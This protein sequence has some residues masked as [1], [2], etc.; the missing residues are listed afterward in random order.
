[1]QAINE[2]F[3]GCTMRAPLPV[4]GK[5]SLIRH[6]S[7]N[8]FAGV[9]SPFSVARYHSLTIGNIPH[10]LE[11]LAQTEDGIIMALAHKQF[12]LFGLQFHPESFLSVGGKE[13][14]KNFLDIAQNFHAFS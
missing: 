10:C 11:V 4:H 8:I 3:G 7:H 2:V 6:N 9:P 12:P 13:I 5:T 1:M 14:I